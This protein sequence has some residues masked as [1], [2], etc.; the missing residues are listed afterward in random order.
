MFFF[1]FFA[2]SFHLIWRGTC[3]PCA[4]PFRPPSA[5]RR[6]PRAAAP[7]RGLS[8]RLAPCRSTSRPTRSSFPVR[9]SRAAAGRNAHARAGR[10]ERGPRG[11]SARACARKPPRAMAKERVQRHPNRWR[12]PGRERP[13]RCAHC[14]A[15]GPRRCC[16]ATEACPRTQSAL[17][18][19]PAR[20]RE[21]LAAAPLRWA[22]SMPPTPAAGVTRRDSIAQLPPPL[23]T[24]SAFVSVERSLALPHPLAAPG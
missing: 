11:G 3:S 9:C 16:W 1:F 21:H 15:P 20:C 2:F 7:P 10:G 13:A 22:I 17:A 24:P 23:H 14:Q 8:R 19:Q 18:G 12:Q 4:I 5:A 6:S